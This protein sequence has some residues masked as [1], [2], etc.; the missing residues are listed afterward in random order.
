MSKI[1]Y[2]LKIF[3]FRKFF[4]LSPKELCGLR[5]MCIF[6]LKLYIKAWFGCTN[7]ISAPFQDINFVKDSIKYEKTN[8]AIST[9][10]IKKMSNHLWYLSEKKVALAFFDTK[11]SFDE[12][13]E[14]VEQLKAKEP[15][16]KLKNNRSNANLLG[17]QNYNLSNFVSEKTKLFFSDFGLSS[18]FLQYDPSIWDTQSDFQEGWSFCKDL[19]VVNDHAERGVKFI[20]D[21]NKVLTTNEEEK[22]MLLQVVEAYRKKYPSYNESALM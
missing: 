7:A 16:V 9:A 5:D 17:F 21:Y 8:P 4:T 18:N 22:Q 2:S 20:K 12:K 11:V 19:S 1:I 15:T 10:I 3:I 6:S 14:M 13:R